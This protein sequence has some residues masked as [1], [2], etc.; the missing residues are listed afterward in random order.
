MNQKS[1]LVIFDKQGVI[2]DKDS[3]GNDPRSTW[4]KRH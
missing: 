3:F 2:K 4:D 1:E